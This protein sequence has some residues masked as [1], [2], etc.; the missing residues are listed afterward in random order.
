MEELELIFGRPEVVLRKGI[1]KLDWPS[2]KN[3][4]K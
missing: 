1:E 4:F 3:L 2:A